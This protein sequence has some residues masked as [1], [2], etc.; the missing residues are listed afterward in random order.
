MHL[1]AEEQDKIGSICG[2]EFQASYDRYM[3][4]FDSLFERY[5]DDVSKNTY[6]KKT[7]DGQLKVLGDI[8]EYGGHTNMGVNKTTESEIIELYEFDG[9]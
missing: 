6:F 9:D 8:T 7:K 3:N 4:K 1:N 5:F 2:N